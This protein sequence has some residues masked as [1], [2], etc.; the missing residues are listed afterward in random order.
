MAGVGSAGGGPGGQ[1]AAGTV[2]RGG[3]AGDGHAPAGGE[4]HGQGG[5]PWIAIISNHGRYPGG[6]SLYRPDADGV[7]RWE[8]DLRPEEL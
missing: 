2:G 1:S 8:R 3:E 5:D 6:R 4:E 7:W